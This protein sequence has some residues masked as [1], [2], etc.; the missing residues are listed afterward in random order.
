MNWHGTCLTLDSVDDQN[1]MRKEINMYKFGKEILEELLQDDTTRE[2]ITKELLELPL[3]YIQTLFKSSCKN[4]GVEFALS[5]WKQ[6]LPT[7]TDD[8]HVWSGTKPEPKQP[9]VTK[10]HFPVNP[11][12]LGNTKLEGDHFVFQFVAVGVDK[13]E[14]TNVTQ[15][16]TSNAVVITLEFENYVRG[17]DLTIA[18]SKVT[19]LAPG[20]EIYLGG[21]KKITFSNG[22]VTIKVPLRDVVRK[23]NWAVE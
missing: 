14:L 8:F 12:Q 20:K 7:L 23:T 3:D 4:Y 18:D 6:L 5:T 11:H 1:I 9:T 13:S 21:T 22:I 10:K 17:I 2:N 16:R 15:T 19:H